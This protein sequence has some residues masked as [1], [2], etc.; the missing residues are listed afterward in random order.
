MLAEPSDDGELLA[1]LTESIELVG[2]GRLELLTGNVRQLSLSDQRLSFSANQFL[3][4]NNDSGTVGLLV[5][6]LGDLVSY[7]LLTYGSR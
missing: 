7:L 1:V 5:F 3:L 2:E 6:E 4:K